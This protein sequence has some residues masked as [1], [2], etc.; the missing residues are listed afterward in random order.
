MYVYI[1]ICIYIYIDIYIYMYRYIYIKSVRRRAHLR[2]HEYSTDLS[3]RPNHQRENP[4]RPPPHIP[5]QSPRWGRQKS[6]VPDVLDFQKSTGVLWHTVCQANPLLESG[7]VHIPILLQFLQ[8]WVLIVQDLHGRLDFDPS[9][10]Q[11]P[12]SPTPPQQPH[13][14]AHIPRHPP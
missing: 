9:K 11:C 2:Q 13:T 8:V 6:I 3:D 10:T 7:M 12:L 4:G 1:Y 14:R 5:R